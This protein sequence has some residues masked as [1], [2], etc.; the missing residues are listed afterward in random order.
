MTP[1]ILSNRAFEVYDEKGEPAMISFL[2][3]NRDRDTEY[4]D[5]YKM[6]IFPLADGSFIEIP[7]GENSYHNPHSGETRPKALGDSQIPPFPMKSVVVLDWPNSETIRDR[8]IRKA[9]REAVD[10]LREEY[11]K[12]GLDPEA[13]PG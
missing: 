13:H 7:L 12:R 10:E 5:P 1:T 3:E 2:V 9:A 6:G 8:V 11:E 4:E